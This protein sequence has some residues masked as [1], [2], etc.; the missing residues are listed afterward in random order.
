MPARHT[1]RSP[2]CDARFLKHNQFGVL[3]DI[4]RSTAARG[5][6][7]AFA[8]DWMYHKRYIA[9]S[10]REACCHNR[11]TRTQPNQSISR[12]WQ[13]KTNARTPSAHKRHANV[14]LNLLYIHCGV[15][16]Y[17]RVRL[18]YRLFL[19]YSL[20]FERDVL[21]L[22]VFIRVLPKE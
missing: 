3:N 14:K 10:Q 16:R 4:V 20:H 11:T 12:L 6:F 13:W 8:V 2:R 15:V 1:V 22:L 18:S 9:A 5:K 21:L 7:D 17:L 19:S